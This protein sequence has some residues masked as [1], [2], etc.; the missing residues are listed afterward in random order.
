MDIDR[1]WLRDITKDSLKIQVSVNG[2]TYV[3]LSR[4]PNEKNVKPSTSRR[5]YESIKTILMYALPD[6]PD[7]CPVEAIRLYLSKL[8]TSSSTL[9]PKPKS[10]SNLK[11]EWYH[12]KLVLGKNSLNDMM[13]SISTKAGLSM[14]FTNHC[15]RATVVTELN[16]KGYSVQEI[17]TVTGHKRPESVSKYIKRTTPTK[18]QKMS[19]DLSSS[20]HGLRTANHI[21][22]AGASNERNQI[23]Q[24][25]HGQSN[26]HQ[27]HSEIR[28]SSNQ[29]GSFFQD[30]KFSNCSFYLSK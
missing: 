11:N 15:I 17:Q 18:K 21:E 26:T 24:T 1:E 6:H 10:I 3:D 23:Q 9:F 2:K 28:L 19:N 13:K 5:H 16:E 12:D 22:P 29:L 27:S 4:P 14:T 7:K 25:N 30:C 8:P 20:L